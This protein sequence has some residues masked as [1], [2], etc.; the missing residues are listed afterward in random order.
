MDTT[1]FRN[2]INRR[3]ALTDSEWALVERFFVPRRLKEGDFLLEEGRICTHLYY[4]D[5][6]LLRF[7]VW[8]DGVDKT[9]FFTFDDYLFTSQYS[10]STRK[11]A[12]ENIQAIEACSLLQISYSDL[13]TLYDQIPNWR[14]FIQSV[15]QEVSHFTEEILTE[16]QTETAENRYR[17]ML[18]EEPAMIQRIPL[19]YLAS[20]LGIAPQSLSR[21]RK[22]LT[23]LT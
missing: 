4:V 16:L 20:Y 6:G 15:I 14:K 11:P 13:Q 21:I 5:K 22:N 23:N 3:V 1:H 17:R 18:T 12:T 2:F 7:F 10:F 8:K 9:K 19:K